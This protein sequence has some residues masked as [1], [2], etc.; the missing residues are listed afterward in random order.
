MKIRNYISLLFLVASDLFALILSFYFSYWLRT[1]F[2]PLIFPLMKKQGFFPINHFYKFFP[3]LFI[4]ILLFFYEKIYFKRHTFWEELIYI[5]RGLFI[6]TILI[7]ILVYFTRAER[8]F[9]RTIILL[10][11]V[12]GII[13][14][15]IMRYIMKYLLFKLKIYWQ[16]IAVIGKSHAIR[17]V[18]K[19]LNEVWYL[20][21]NVAGFITSGKVKIKNG[22]FLG[23]L[24][25]LKN[26]VKKYRLDGVVII[27]ERFSKN[28]L[29]NIIAKCESIL[30]EIKLIPDVLTLKTI[31]VHPEYVNEI[32]LLSVSNNLAIPIN[33]FYK[34]L[35][36]LVFAL[37]VSILLI[38]FFVL[39]GILIKLDS[40]GPIFF[41]QERIGYKGKLFKF[42]KFRTMYIDGDKRLKDFIKKHK[43]AQIEWKRY[44][45]LKKY[46]PRV[47]RIGKFLRRFSIDELPQIFNVL[48]G[49]MSIVGP[50]PYLPREKE[51]IG[52]YFSIFFKV[53]PGLTGLW[54][55]RGRNELSFN[56]RLKLDE[57][58]VRN[59]S[60]FLDLMIIFKTIEVV[61]AG[62]GAY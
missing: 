44:Q 26:I 50:R 17:K 60:F 4:Y 34:R 48:I 45:K 28:E 27:E 61:L 36:D 14:V 33:K 54:Q 13:F 24:K 1:E 20:G 16:R 7:A 51:I 62:K 15:P 49:D 53:K 38:P 58:Y 29:N 18:Y 52:K 2:L 43:W 59:W 55:I 6:S 12:S 3:V 47:T 56:T 35:F 10:M 22:K 5:L 11:F 46:D 37:T 23:N 39:I 30:P 41:V 57:F 42:I 9:A 31:G 32:L 40:R 25:K 8:L 21:Y 19:T